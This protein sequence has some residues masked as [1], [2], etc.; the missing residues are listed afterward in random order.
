MQNQDSM[1]NF[2]FKFSLICLKYIFYDSSIMRMKKALKS[3][4]EYWNVNLRAPY[5]MK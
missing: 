3:V 5:L 1:Y 4:V 2:F